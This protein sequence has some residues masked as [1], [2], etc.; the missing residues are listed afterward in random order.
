MKLLTEDRYEEYEAFVQSNKK[1]HFAQSLYWAKLKDNWKHEVLLVENPD[2]SIRAS[3]LVLIRKMPGISKT[4]MYSPRG[5][6]CDMHDKEAIKELLDG[7]RELAKIHK[8]YVLKIDPDIKASDEEFAAIAKDLG[9]MPRKKT[10]NFEEIQPRYVFRLD[11]AGKTEDE[12]F[13]AFHNKTRYNVRLST[14]KGVT[15]EIGTREDL[16]R[17]HE[18]M[19]ET[20]LRDGFVIRSLEYFQKMYDALGDHIRLYVAKY[21]GQIISATLAILYGNKVWYLYGAS[22]NQFRNVMPNYLLQWD[23]IKWAIEEKCDIYDFRGVSGDIDESNPLYGLYRFKKGFSGEFTEFIG[24]LDY[25]FD[26]P[27]YVILEKAQIVYRNL[28]RKVF[29]K[30]NRS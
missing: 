8:S 13:A 1:G 11:V 14:R 20:G 26:K 28:R 7:A 16:P 29:L 21:Q 9:L 17:F 24:E 27:M 6:V 5:P 3:M 30:K 25:V 22:S 19:M 2:G 10:K 12:I 15:S 18:I 4:M 23:M